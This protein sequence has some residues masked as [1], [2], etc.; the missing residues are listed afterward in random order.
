MGSLVASSLHPILHCIPMA[1]ESFEA[2]SNELAGTREIPCMRDVQHYHATGDIVILAEHTLFKVH[3]SFLARDES[4]FVHMFDHGTVSDRAQSV[5]VSQNLTDDDPLHLPDSAEDV[6]CLLWALY[7]LP[8]EI[9]RQESDD[10]NVERLMSLAVISNKYNFITLEKW[11][12]EVILHH[13]SK[14]YI[15]SCP[16]G[17][18]DVLA[19]IAVRAEPE[20]PQLVGTLRLKCLDRL[21]LKSDNRAVSHALDVGETHGWRE[22]Q[23]HLYFRE[24]VQICSNPCSE[25]SLSTAP[26][27]AAELTD[28]QKRRLM[29][30]CY[31]LT[32][33]WDRFYRKHVNVDDPGSESVYVNG[34]YTQRPT[35]WT[36][37]LSLI[38]KAS[39]CAIVDIPARVERM[40]QALHS[41]DGHQEVY[42]AESMLSDL[43][44]D[45]DTSLP[46]HF[47]GPVAVD[48]D[49]SIEGTTIDSN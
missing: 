24:A 16:L 20:L 7:A 27:T 15:I 4:M 36:R 46:D 30:G 28:A 31:S 34:R 39:P 49:R 14:S 25:A 5:P 23:G 3:R 38:A 22:F 8:F 35:Q 6:R 43:L 11:S 12:A 26:S 29:I 9:R 13:C 19:E 21:L 2:T 42:D 1:T 45:F 47:L 33:L 18:L 44:N 40:K 17:Q 48:V 37:K 10:A 41:N 32:L